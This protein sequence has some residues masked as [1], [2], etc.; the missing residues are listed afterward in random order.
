MGTRDLYK[1]GESLIVAG[2]GGSGTNMA[3]NIYYIA[4]NIYFGS[5]LHAFHA[6][7]DPD[8]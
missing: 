8:F 1:F 5:D 3:L 6:D 2:S 7:P 4:T